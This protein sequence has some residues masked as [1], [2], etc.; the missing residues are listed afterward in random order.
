MAAVLEAR[1]RRI[2]KV[3]RWELWVGTS[4]V[5]LCKPGKHIECASLKEVLVLEFEATYE[6]AEK[7]KR[8]LLP[9]KFVSVSK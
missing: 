7:L 4:T 1:G 5:E 8:A 3:E 2:V 9:I 6:D